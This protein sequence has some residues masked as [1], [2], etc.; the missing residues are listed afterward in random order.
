MR[1]SYWETS[2]GGAQCVCESDLDSSLVEA[3]A[4][5]VQVYIH[6]PLPA[7]LNDSLHMVS[8]QV[9]S[10]QSSASMKPELGHLLSAWC[11]VLHTGK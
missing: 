7:S 1:S 9:A 8:G 6:T 4:F 10:V 11:F 2:S 5:M 3:Q